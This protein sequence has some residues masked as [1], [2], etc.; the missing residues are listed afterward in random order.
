[1]T[2][3]REQAISAAFFKS[4]EGYDYDALG[5][6]GTELSNA[7]EQ[8]RNVR[9]GEMDQKLYRELLWVD[10]TLN[11]AVMT[12]TLKAAKEAA[13]SVIN[14][15]ARLNALDGNKFSPKSS[16]VELKLI[17]GGRSDSSH[18]NQNI[19]NAPEF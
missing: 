9:K 12:I 1:M 3:L 16:T 5:H 15:Q 18:E 2:A 4:L 17:Q 11:T 8:L 19:K 7:S 10:A 6:I 13:Q 14:E